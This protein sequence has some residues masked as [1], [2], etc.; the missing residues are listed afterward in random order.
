MAKHEPE[1]LPTNQIPLINQQRQ[2]YPPQQPPR[3]AWVPPDEA[4]WQA[5]HPQP[6]EPAKKKRRI[7]PWVFLAIQILFLVWA[8]AGGHSAATDTSHC[9]SLS[10]Q[11]CKSASEAGAGIGI[12]LVIILWA[13][14]DVILG[15][16]YIVFRLSRRK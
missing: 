3:P 8:I 6:A 9:G 1:H 10:A 12:A 16:V 15:M 14:V 7:F 5:T 11:D 2:Q 13:V 4:E